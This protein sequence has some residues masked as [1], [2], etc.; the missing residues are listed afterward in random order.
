MNT[1][2][3]GKMLLIIIVSLSYENKMLC[4]DQEYDEGGHCSGYND[5]SEEATTVTSDRDNQNT[6]PNIETVIDWIGKNQ[7]ESIEK[8]IGYIAHYIG[9]KKTSRQILEATK[10]CIESYVSNQETKYPVPA[11]LIIEILRHSK[12]YAYKITES[13]CKNI[14]QLV[15]QDLVSIYSNFKEIAT[16]QSL[17]QAYSHYKPGKQIWMTLIFS[18]HSILECINIHVDAHNTS[19]VPPDSQTL[20]LWQAEIIALKDLQTFCISAANQIEK[21]K[22]A[23]IKSPGIKMRASAGKTPVS[24]SYEKANQLSQLEQM[25]D[26]DSDE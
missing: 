3:F 14:K 20:N 19:D 6:K 11:I 26:I 12:E 8:N 7:H 23:L 18:I 21:N 17:N 9:N 25:T 5:Y 16:Y 1:M 10:E 4:M 22:S 24:S 13:I 2:K 15:A